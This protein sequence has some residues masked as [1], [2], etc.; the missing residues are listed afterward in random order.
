[1]S[2]KKSKKS[3]EAELP[4]DVKSTLA[5]MYCEAE[6]DAESGSDDAG[7]WEFDFACLTS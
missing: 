1:M 4:A 3:L 6:G 2:E 5:N 7:D